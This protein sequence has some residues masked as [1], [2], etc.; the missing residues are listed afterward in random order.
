M[1]CVSVVKMAW[2]WG[3][4]KVENLY[5]RLRGKVVDGML[6]LKKLG[7]E[8]PR[9]VV[10]SLKVGLAITLVSTFY[11]FEPLYHGF[12]SS[13]MWAIFTVIVVSEFSVGA[14]LG[15][16]LNRGLATFLAGALGLGCFYLAESTGHV[17]QPILLGVFIF[18]LAAGVTYMRFFPQMKKKYDYGLMVF[19][20]TFC[21][22][23][24]SSYREDQEI[25]DIAQK[26]VITILIGGLISVLV[27]IFVCPIWAGDDLHNLVSRNID[28]LGNF[29]QG[30]GDEYFRTS[31]EGEGEECDKAVLE[32]YKSVLNSKQTEESLAN[33]VTW[34][35][36]HGRFKYQYPWHQYLKIGSL[37]RQCA[38]RI[39]A[40]N[41][42]LNS[43]KAPPEGIKGK[44]QEACMKMSKEAGRGLKELSEAMK[45]MEAPLSAEAHISKAKTGAMKLRSIM[46]RGLWEEGNNV[47]LVEA[48]PA[49]TVA[50][51]LLDVVSCTEQLGDSIKHLS[52]L[53]NFTTN[54]LKPE[55]LH[56][57]QITQTPQPQPQEA[58]QSCES[59]NSGHH[60][61][62]TI[63]PTPT[64]T[65]QVS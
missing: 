64:T 65:N 2:E 17:V 10:H 20:L 31:T 21:L 8:D 11:Y 30:F 45:R 16:G 52:S 48:I 53:A 9:R 36:C 34:E 14:T 26:R 18:V 44:L 6:E 22:V 7:E 46:K 58:L 38:Y 12:G 56:N 50:S 1:W 43:A 19:I 39:D 33:F 25:I 37:S 59:H 60:H 55:P 35:P 24:V 28:K 57:N 63:N 15:K 61:V 49:M 4:G 27:C 40:L 3:N 32:G 42:F 5:G 23:S 54:K 47:N 13:A 29:L 41:G 51:L 62:I